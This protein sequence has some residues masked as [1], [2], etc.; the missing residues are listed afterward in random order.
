MRKRGKAQVSVEFS[1]LIGFVTFLLL[2]SIG[3]AYYYSGTAKDQ[4]RVNAVDKAGKKIAET[5]DSICALG[6]PSKATIQVTIP[7]SVESFSATNEGIFFNVKFRDHVGNMFY[8]TQ[9]KV[10]VTDEARMSLAKE[11]TK[12]IILKVIEDTVEISK[13]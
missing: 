2:A 11:G 1:L 9:C 5:I 6:A 7:E 3:I 8:K 12:T 10:N 13:K 4:I